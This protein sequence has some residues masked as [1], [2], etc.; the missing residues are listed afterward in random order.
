MAPSSGSG[1]DGMA[2]PRQ[3]PRT[4]IEASSRSR[5]GRGPSHSLF[6]R[7]RFTLGIAL[8]HADDVFVEPVV[9]RAEASHGQPESMCILTRTH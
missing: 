8:S 6:P 4:A 1:G 9:E 5:G 7:H 3:G 2:V